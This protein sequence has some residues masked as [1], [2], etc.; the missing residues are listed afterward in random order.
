MFI[1]SFSLY[2]PPNPK[3]YDGLLDN[4]RLI[5]TY[6]PGWGVYVYVGSDV[7]ATFV[8][9]LQADPIVRIHETGIVGHRN[10]IYR[11]FAIDEPDVEA[12]FFRDADSRIHWK[13]RWAIRDFLKSGQDVHII[14]DHVEHT[15]RL[16]A[17]LWGIRKGVL[18]RSI[19]DMYTSWTPEF[20]GSGNENDPAGF[21]IDQNFLVLELYR[22]LKHRA[23][24]NYS[25]G[26]LYPGETGTEFPFD[27]TN[28]VYCGRQELNTAA[29]YVDVPARE[30]RS[31]ALQLPGVAIRL[32]SSK[33]S[34]PNVPTLPPV[35]VP[36]FVI[37]QPTSL[38]AFPNFL[39]RK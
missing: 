25:C 21:G 18:S 31:G 11:F 17:G 20:A 6:F 38:P 10:S 35:Q 16:L 30:R 24:V 37:R 7:P 39:Y 8:Q 36:S 1:F 32:R 15:T 3:Y 26:K 4:I 2:G 28:D 5:H 19:R 13:D 29:A 14:R 23:Y 22:I 34:T 12:A 9:T 33:D 27:W